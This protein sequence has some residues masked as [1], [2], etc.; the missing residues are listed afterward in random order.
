MTWALRTIL[1]ATDLGGA[2]DDVVRSAALLAERSGAALYLIHSLELPGVPSDEVMRRAGFFEQIASA[3]ERLEE[4]VRRTMPAGLRPSGQEVIMYVAHKAI[5][6]R[7][8]DVGADLIVVGPHRGGGVGAH[9][10]GTTADRV[11][12]T[13]GVPCMIARGSMEKGIRRI[14]VALDL[15]ESSPETLAAAM[16]LDAR[17]A[18]AGDGER[19]ARIHVMHAG[20]SAEMN[21]DLE[22]RVIRPALAAQVEGA[23]SR[24]QGGKDLPVE[25]EVL[26]ANEPVD[27][28]VRWASK[29]GLDLL[30]MGTEGRSGLKRAILGSIASRVSR[31]VSC[32]VLLVPPGTERGEE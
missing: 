1:A 8:R 26:W 11:I 20:W 30:V 17:L 28:I 24:T 12:R 3:K 16:A 5:V 6:E 32:P 4:Q 18:E 22:E 27:C 14:G 13:A 25:I 21:D 15:S 7:A 9:F 19:L 29:R 31:Q 10:I 2:S 23:R